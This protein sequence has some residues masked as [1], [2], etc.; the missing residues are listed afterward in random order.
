MNF[1][2]PTFPNTTINPLFSR[3]LAGMDPLF[4]AYGWSDNEFGFVWMTES[5]GDIVQY[6]ADRLALFAL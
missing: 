4:S 1:R 5:S 6:I 2:T 3:A